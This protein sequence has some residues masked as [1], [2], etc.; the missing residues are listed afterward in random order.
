MYFATLQ[1]QNWQEMERKFFYIKLIKIR[2][3]KAG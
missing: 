1:P 2:V 3:G